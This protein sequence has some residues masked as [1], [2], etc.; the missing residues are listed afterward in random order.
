MPKGGVAFIGPSD[1]HTSTKYNN[2]I[3]AYMYDAMLNHG[4]VELGPAMQA[5]QYGLTK[6][7]PAQN[8]PGEA[9]EFYA[10]VYNIL[11]DPSLQ[12]YLD[13]PKQF[14]IEANEVSPKDG[15]LQLLIKNSGT[16][17]VVAGVVLSVMANGE[18]LAKGVADDSGSFVTT[19][20][21]SGLTSV[22]VYAN[23]GS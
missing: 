19:L 20:D 8:G 13:R 23:K 7:F 15:L 18:M 6:E 22:T 12:V 16:G 5:G 14:L 17:Q 21:A 4:V 11:G 3:N 2:V 1:L 10:N 9:Q